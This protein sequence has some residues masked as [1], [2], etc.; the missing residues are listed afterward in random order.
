MLSKVRIWIIQRVG[1][2]VFATLGY[3]D[4]NWGILKLTTEQQKYDCDCGAETLQTCERG[5][6]R[7]WKHARIIGGVG[8]HRSYKRRPDGLGKYRFHVDGR[9]GSIPVRLPGT[10]DIVC[11]GPGRSL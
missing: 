3:S 10:S 9:R 5:V 8:P 1:N 11:F 6:G 4:A 2:K 7:A